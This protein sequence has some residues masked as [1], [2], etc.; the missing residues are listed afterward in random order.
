M[1]SDERLNELRLSGE[2]VRVV[3]DELDSNDVIGIVVAWDPTHVIIRR[4]NRRVVKLDR[5]YSYQLYSEPRTS[6]LENL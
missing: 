3:R 6:P 5:N 4:R 1:I 2:R